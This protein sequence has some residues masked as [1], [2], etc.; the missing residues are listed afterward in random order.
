LSRSPSRRAPLEPTDRVADVP[1]LRVIAVA[2]AALLTAARGAGAFAVVEGAVTLPPTSAAPAPKPR[3]PV[4]A[5]YTVG[6]PDPPAAIVYL[7]GDLPAPTPVRAEMGQ[8]HYQFAPG[9]LAVP[10]GSTVAFPNHDPEYHSVFSYSKAKRFDLGRYRPDE[11]PPTVVFDTPGVVR[12]YC[13]IHDHMRGTI[14]VLDSPYVTRTD[15]E[16]RYR[17]EGLPAGAFTLVAWI[18]EQTVRRRPVTVQDGVTIHVDFPA[19]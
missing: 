4:A 3:Y 12:L 7:E 14:L 16:G 10:R 8:Q 13:E 11:V 19:G 18:D 2:A 9:L 17:L 15:P 6:P 5:T 1:L